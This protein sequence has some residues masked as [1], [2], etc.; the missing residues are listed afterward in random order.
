MPRNGRFMNRPYIDDVNYTY[1]SNVDFYRI[2]PVK[3]NF[4][5]ENKMKKSTRRLLAFLSAAAMA[6]SLTACAG[7][8]GGSGDTQAGDIPEGKIFAEGTEISITIASH[9]SWPYNQDWKIWQYFQEETGAK[10]NVTAIP[11]ADYSTK[12][13]L[14]MANSE[15]LPDLLN[16][17]I[18]GEQVNRY[19]TT[20]AFISY[21]DNMDKMPNYQAFLD[22]LDE[23]ERTELLNQRRCGDGKIYSAPVYGTQRVTNLRAWMYRKDIFDKHGLKPPTTYEEMYEVAKK[24]KEIYPDSYPI[25]CRNMLYNFQD[26]STAWKTGLTYLHYYDYEAGEW[27]FGSR[28]PLIKQMVEYYRKL[29]DEKLIQP[30]FVNPDAKVWEELMSTDRGF[31]MFD[32]VTRIDYF[33]NACRVENPEYTMAVMTP[34]VPPVETGNAS[35]AKTNF[36]FMGYCICNTGDK[37]ANDNAFKLVDWMYSPEGVEILSW[38]KEGETYEVVDGKKKFIVSEGEDAR[39]KYG[40]GTYGLYQV[41]DQDAFESTYTPENIAASIEV[42]KHMEKKSNPNKWLALDE[43][44]EKRASDIFE[45][46]WTY[47]DEEISKFLLGQKPMSEWDTFVAGLDD[48]QV[49]EL[50]QI[51]DEAYTAAMSK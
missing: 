36:D 24:L 34:P 41:I 48:M 40:V 16:T 33:N 43:D 30:E 4:K 42:G 6:L 9:A 23:V 29:N 35:V 39:V 1:R 20:G 49:D 37:Q 7:G 17:F 27:K 15:E 31:I 8:N 12:L 22:G 46:L 5:E 19:A 45:D 14:M 18:K 26:F 3:I 10:L 47:C 25:C 11:S 13:P 32:Y 38:G 44:A 51:W 50:L 2:T 21:D 28:D